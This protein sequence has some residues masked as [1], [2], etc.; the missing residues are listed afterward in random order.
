MGFG[1]GCDT[2]IIHPLHSPPYR[3]SEEERTKRTE[4]RKLCHIT[5]QGRTRFGPQV[6]FSN[7]GTNR[8]KIFLF[9]QVLKFLSVLDHN[10]C[11]LQDL[12]MRSPVHSRTLNIT[13]HTCTAQGWTGMYILVVPFLSTKFIKNSHQNLPV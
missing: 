10:T 5:C 4:R 9:A 11:L 12:K 6:A 2:F 7:P 1:V 8:V 3:A 13:S